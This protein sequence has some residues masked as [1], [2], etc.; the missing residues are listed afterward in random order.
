MR[1]RW[2]TYATDD[3]ISI[4]DHIARDSRQYAVVVVDRILHRV[5]QLEMFPESGSIVPEY[6][7]DDVREIFVHTYRIIHQRHGNEVRILTVCHGANPLPPTP[8]EIR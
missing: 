2:T 7:R 1:V 4:Q 6:R 8:P 5:T 3:L